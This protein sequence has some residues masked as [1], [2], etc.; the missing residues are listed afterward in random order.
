MPTILDE[1][2]DH[3]EDLAL[4]FP[5]R[6]C[7]ACGETKPRKA[8]NKNKSAKDGLQTYCRE[9]QTKVK[10][11]ERKSTKAKHDFQDRRCLGC[12]ELFPSTGPANRI[13]GKC[14]GRDIYSE[15][16]LNLQTVGVE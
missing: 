10:V 8:F 16:D 9:Y 14:S 3:E 12:G 11:Q 13:C 6:R 1:I 2:F 5:T 7:P 15:D 4:L